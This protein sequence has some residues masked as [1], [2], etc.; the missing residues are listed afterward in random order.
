VRYLFNSIEQQEPFADNIKPQNAFVQWLVTHHPLTALQFLYGNGRYMLKKMR[1][2]WTVSS[3]QGSR[4]QE[5]LDKRNKLEREWKTPAGALLEVD[6]QRADS[7]FRE[8]KDFTWKV[9]RVATLCWEA[10]L[11]VATIVLAALLIGG[12]SV[13]ANV[14]APV[15]PA[16][17]HLWLGSI[18]SRYPGAIVQV[19]NVLQ[20]L[21]TF[22]LIAV[23]I[24]LSD[25]I[26]K[27]IRSFSVPKK[28]DLCYLVGKAGYASSQMK[29]K[30]VTMG[31]THDTDLASVGDN[32]EYFNTGTWTKV[33]SPEEKLTRDESELVFLQGLR[34][35]N[36][37]LTCYLMKWMDGAGEPRLVK[38]FSDEVGCWDKKTRPMG[39][40][41]AREQQDESARAHNA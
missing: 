29:V 22:C 18:A 35:S 2:A 15:L 16:A 12:I 36:G 4:K 5:H 25:A 41:P 3:D 31:H 40:P 11:V 30:Y 20:W 8:T 10:S 17:L 26:G 24:A 21:A 34:D 23:L 1:R 39:E 28:A 19:F 7:V 14:V 33:F 6:N 37:E 27:W 9:M 32:A 13:V 38:L